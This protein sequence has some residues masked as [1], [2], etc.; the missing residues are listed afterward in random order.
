MTMQIKRDII[1]SRRPLR[2]LCPEK[3]LRINTALILHF[4]LLY[5]LMQNMFHLNDLR[6][7]E[8]TGLL[9]GRRDSF[10]WQNA[11]RFGK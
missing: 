8:V 7:S 5:L 9:A 4:F 3:A 11:N 1:N 2:L 10:N 6:V